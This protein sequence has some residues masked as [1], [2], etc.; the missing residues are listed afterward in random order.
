AD[1]IAERFESLGLA[2]LDGLDGYF[3]PFDFPFGRELKE[4]ATSLKVGDAE[5]LAVGKDFMP[6]AWSTPKEFE[7]EFVFAGYGINSEQYGY[8]DYADIDVQGKVVLVLNYEPV[9]ADGKS[10]FTN[11]ERPS[12]ESRLFSKANAA[13]EAGA[14]ALLVVNPVM[15]RDEPDQLMP[16]GRGSTRTE[17]PVIQ[18]TQSA[19]AAMLREAGLP[20][21]RRL[22]QEIDEGGAPVTHEPKEA[23]TISGGFAPEDR[24]IPVKNVVGMVEGKKAD[25]FI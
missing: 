6:M 1:Y 16:F 19:A 14:A 3:Q 4:D 10:R 18:V 21:L 11:T 23:V 9:T 2:K 13:Q 7:G 5:G 22:Q 8:N 12:R 24:K 20:P 15:H 17:I 25:E